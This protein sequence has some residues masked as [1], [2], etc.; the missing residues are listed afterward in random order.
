MPADASRNQR[1]G[2]G[3]AFADPPPPRAAA[4]SAPRGGGRS[5]TDDVEYSNRADLRAVLDAFGIE[6]AALVGNSRGAMICL[7][8]ILE[9]P[10]RAIAFAWVGGGVG[11]FAGGAGAGGRARVR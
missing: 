11:G 1:L 8:T 6:R 9:S 2:W 10:D 4:R 5:T 3:G 7:D